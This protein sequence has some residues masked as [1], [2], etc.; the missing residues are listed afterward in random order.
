MTETGRFA[1]AGATVLVGRDLT[2]K[3]NKTI[4]VEGSTI[5]A[6]TDEPN[7]ALDDVVEATD[8]TVIPGFIDAHVHVGFVDPA[9][10]V[11]RGV[12]TVRDLGWP[13]GLILG[14]ARAS[15]DRSFD[16]PLILAAGP[17]LTV[18][19][20]YPITASW[21]P[22]GTG[23]AVA[24]AAEARSAVRWLAE[25]GAAVIK[26]AL[27]PPAGDVMSED[28]LAAVVAE[29]HQRNLRVTAHIHGLDQLHKALRAGIDELAHMLLSPEHLDDDSITLMVENQVAIVPTLSIFPTR[30][31]EIAIANLARFVS[32]GGRV[33]Y[34]TDL[35]NEGPQPGIDATEITRM[36]RAGM[37]VG[38]IIRSA[39]VAAAEWLGLPGKGAIAPG[40]DADL[41]C[42]DGDVTDARSLTRVARVYREGAEMPSRS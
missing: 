21:A 8:Q 12:T 4:V 37:S 33:V 11:A 17:M 31:A 41:V 36:E 24:N 10:V 14:L 7:D 42:I 40:M 28:V 29:A 22:E 25:N 2:P 16:G 38:D 20:G 1:L 5:A 35:G 13:P 27:N 23:L 9:D 3:R 19:G 32:A 18:E 26:V 30:D 15:R 34:G 6:V 39:T